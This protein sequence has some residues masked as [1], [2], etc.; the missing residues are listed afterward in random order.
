MHYGYITL[1]TNV[2]QTQCVTDMKC[3]FPECKGMYSVWTKY[4]VKIINFMCVLDIWAGRKVRMMR[5]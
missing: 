1:E 2:E 4:I 5:F 3:N